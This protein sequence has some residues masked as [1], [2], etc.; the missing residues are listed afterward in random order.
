MTITLDQIRQIAK[1]PASSVLPDAVVQLYKSNAELIMTE[2]FASANLSTERY[3]LIWLYLAAH[4]AVV[5]EEYG[6]VVQMTV[7]QSEERYTDLGV[8]R[9]GL[10]STRYGQQAIALD[11]S[12]TLAA[13]STSPIRAQFRII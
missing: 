5:S 12:G 2:E 9:F 6:G 4:F 7:G 11:S 13:M 1:L 8:S 3:D 10:S